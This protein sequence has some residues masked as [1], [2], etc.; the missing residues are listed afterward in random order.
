MSKDVQV[1]QC[2][3]KFARENSL[4]HI[5]ATN[6]DDGS[7]ILMIE[8]GFNVNQTNATGETALHYACIVNIVNLLFSA[9]ANL[10]AI[11]HKDET[12]IM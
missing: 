11:S 6:D 8:N 2:L 12:P 3:L 9:G 5:A 4:L 10:N 1:V 7:I